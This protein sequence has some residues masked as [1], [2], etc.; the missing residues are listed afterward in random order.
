MSLPQPVLESQLASAKAKLAGIESLL[1]GGPH[2][3]HPVWRRA[4]ARVRQ[5]E[6]RLNRVAEVRKIDAERQAAQ[7][8]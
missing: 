4:N 6:G 8:E 1:G 7:G 5:I 2:K 3:K